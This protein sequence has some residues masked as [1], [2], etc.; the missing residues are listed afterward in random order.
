MDKELKDIL[1]C[2]MKYTSDGDSEQDAKYLEV[3]QTDLVM[4]FNKSVCDCTE[5]DEPTHVIKCKKCG[6]P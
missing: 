4:Y 3:I 5:F 2:L 1:D 6:T